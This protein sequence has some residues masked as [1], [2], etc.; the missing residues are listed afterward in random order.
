MN[1]TALSRA[2]VHARRYARQR[3]KLDRINLSDKIGKLPAAG[4]AVE[5]IANAPAELH[6][7]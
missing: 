5:L 4:Y 7:G 1:T 3:M 6:V 2:E